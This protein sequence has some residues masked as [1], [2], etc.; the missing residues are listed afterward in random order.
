RLLDMTRTAVN[1]ASDSSVALIVAHGEGEVD[2][3]VL[4]AEN[5]VEPRSL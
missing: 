3:T 2:E 4:F 1:I 5:V